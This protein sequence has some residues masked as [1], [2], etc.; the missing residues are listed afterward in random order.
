MLYFILRNKFKDPQFFQVFCK[1]LPEEFWI[2]PFK[3]LAVV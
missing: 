2:V 3:I 1:Y